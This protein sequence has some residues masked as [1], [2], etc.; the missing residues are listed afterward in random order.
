MKVP[1]VSLTEARRAGLL[2]AVSVYPVTRLAGT[3]PR[4][5]LDR[6][7]VSGA[8]MAFAF[9]AA[10]ATTGAV[11][12]AVVP[13]AS[14]ELQRDRRT[15]LATGLLAV[16]AGYAAVRVRAR[17]RAAAEAGE[18]LPV[19]VAASGAAAEVVAVSAAA[20]AA[21]SSAD[22]VGVVL[23]EVLRPRHPVVVVTGVL[24]AGAAIAAVSRH[25]RA[26]AYFT[27]P[28]AEGSSARDLTF[29]TGATLPVA[30]GRA[31]AVAG[32]ALA[33]LALETA[34]PAAAE[35]ATTSAA[36]PDA[37]TATGSRPPATAAARARAR[38]RTAA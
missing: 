9:A 21:V 11:R 3:L 8:S 37:A 1:T 12:R 30:V 35:M 29:Q 7:V 26:L 25:P 17:A 5:A 32:A 19:A 14:S 18:R 20:G 2:A 27:L 38:T 36:A 16:G 15:A 34:A 6:A 10:S 23:P 31:A 28:S 13:G 22:I 24:V 33:V 4:P